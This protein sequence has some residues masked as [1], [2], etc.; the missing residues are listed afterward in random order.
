M[1]KCWKW[2]HRDRPSANELYQNFQ[3]Y[4]IYA[5]P[6][7]EQY[8]DGNSEDSIDFCNSESPA[9]VATVSAA[10]PGAQVYSVGSATGDGIESVNDI[11]G[12]VPNKLATKMETLPRPA[13][14]KEARGSIAILPKKLNGWRLSH[15]TTS[16]WCELTD[17]EPSV[18][19]WASAVVDTAH[20]KEMFAAMHKVES[21]SE[22]ESEEEEE[23]SSDDGEGVYGAPNDD[24]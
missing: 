19:E 8:L 20:D 11:Y 10:G 1:R 9:N 23:L 16:C 18:E 6:D 24:E 17:R 5:I 4:A 14:F 12:P 2:D 22:S 21:E 13:F 15:K 7:L 3:N